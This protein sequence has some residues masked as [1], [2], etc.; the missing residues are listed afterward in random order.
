MCN[1][2]IITESLHFLSIISMGI[3]ADFARAAVA[4]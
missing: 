4:F 1:K 2:M 3:L